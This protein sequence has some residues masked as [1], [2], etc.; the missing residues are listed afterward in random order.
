MGIEM[1][2][3]PALQHFSDIAPLVVGTG[4]Q[5]SKPK[6]PVTV[7]NAEI[8]QWEPLLNKMINDFLKFWAKG[9]TVSSLCEEATI[10]R[11]GMSIADLRQ[12]GRI[13]VYRQLLWLKE[14][15][16]PTRVDGATFQTLMHTHL[17]NK[18]QSLSRIHTNA[19]HG[20]GIIGME[21]H[22]LKLLK[23]IETV[24]SFPDMELSACES[25]LQSTLC[26]V[27][28]EVQRIVKVG[29]FLE[30]K[31]LRPKFKAALDIAAHVRNKLGRL[32]VVHH[33][34][35]SE[36]LTSRSEGPRDSD[37]LRY[38]PVDDITP[39]THLIVKRLMEKEMETNESNAPS[40][41]EATTEVVDGVTVTTPPVKKKRNSRGG[42]FRIFAVAK[43]KGLP[44]SH[45]EIATLLGKSASAFSNILHDRSEGDAAFK[46]R[47]VEVFGETMETLR[48]PI[49]ATEAP[50]VTEE[51]ITV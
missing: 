30:G 6:L 51:K 11:L 2:V 16:D 13:H 35:L 47:V 42:N 27:N 22:R 29:M 1:T 23:F 33:V 25:L 31:R 26:A 32:E 37:R 38:E 14:N 36:T 12:I 5:V 49:A 18:F 34:S 7:T 17:K 3:A 28:V 44:T 8:E 46:L 45:G 9:N 48:Q 20:G 40:S 41:T 43:E 24:E 15:H 39:E 4:L 50:V 21:E 10:G 19:K